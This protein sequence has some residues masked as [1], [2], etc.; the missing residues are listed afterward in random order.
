METGVISFIHH[1]LGK[2]HGVGRAVHLVDSQADSGKL[3]THRSQLSS[4]PEEETTVTHTVSK[5]PVV[6]TDYLIAIYGSGM[7]STWIGITL[8]AVL[9][10]LEADLCLLMGT[11]FLKES[12]MRSLAGE[13]QFLEG[14]ICV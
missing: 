4:I 13:G 7:I 1:I 2:E 12:D 11:I 8:L 6:I 14:N 10:Q 9:P 5:A 3:N